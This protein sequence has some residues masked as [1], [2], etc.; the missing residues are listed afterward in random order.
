MIDN[1]ILDEGLELSWEFWKARILLRWVKGVGEWVGG[2]WVVEISSLFIPLISNF[3]SDLR[4]PLSLSL[5]LSISLSPSRQWWAAHQRAGGA[6]AA[7]RRRTGRARGRWPAAISGGVA[8]GGKCQGVSTALSLLLLLLVHPPF[9]LANDK[10]SRGL[11]IYIVF[12]EYL[13]ISWIQ[14]VAPLIG[15]LK[16]LYTIMI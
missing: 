8:R 5:S 10:V 6:Q 9:V 7:R 12:T 14:L 2:R 3:F 4:Y 15:D 11:C 13:M 1:L 16:F